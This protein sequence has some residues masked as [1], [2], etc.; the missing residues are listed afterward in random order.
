MKYQLTKQ[1]YTDFQSVK[2][3]LHDFDCFVD[4][5]LMLKLDEQIDADLREHLIK[6][7]GYILF[8]LSD[9]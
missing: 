8:T 1:L 6:I 9:E 7:V 4:L 5:S 3:R 2:N